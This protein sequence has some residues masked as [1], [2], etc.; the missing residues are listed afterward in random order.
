MSG[1]DFPIALRLEGR[2]VLLVGAGKIATGRLLQLLEVGAKVHVVAPTVSDEIERLVAS[3]AV[4]LSRRGFEP[5]DCE[6]AA[7]VFSA[8][9]DL[10][11]TAA[12]V[13]EAR[14]RGL[15]VNAADVP[16]LCDFYVPSFG[17]RGQVT[18]AVS[19]A[20][21][22]P[23]LSHALKERAMA[24]IGPEWGKLARLVG[25]LRRITPAG[26]ARTAAIATL[27]GSDAAASLARGDRS[28]VWK[29]IRA[30]WP[31]GARS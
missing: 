8:T 12:V 27:V 13:A 21:A 11:V 4:R 18:V 16:S 10:S 28:A 30:V 23:G 5:V 31:Q 24:A 29:R 7:I 20:G 17:R 26:P 14:R 1:L 15:L 25:R 6:G 19:T 3:G 9:D 22:A 2:Q